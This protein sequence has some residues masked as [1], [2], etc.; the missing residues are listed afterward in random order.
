MRRMVALETKPS[1][2]RGGAKKRMGLK[3]TLLPNGRERTT[4]T[5]VSN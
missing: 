3:R 1:V 2:Q 5:G 4:H